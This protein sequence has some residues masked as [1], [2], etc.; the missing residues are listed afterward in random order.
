MLVAK[1][2]PTNRAITTYVYA[3]SDKKRVVTLKQLISKSE[4][5]ERLGPGDKVADDL[6]IAPIS[7]QTF[8]SLRSQYMNKGIRPGRPTQAYGVFSGGKLMGAYAIDVSGTK[9]VWEKHLSTPAIYLMSDFPVEP[10]DYDK[11]AKL[12]IVAAL[13]KESKLL[14]ERLTRRRVK[15]IITTAFSKNPVSMKYRGLF[16]LLKRKENKIL[17][18]TDWAKEV[19]NDYYRRPF[20]LEYG[21][22]AGQWTLAEGLEI[23]KKKYSQRFGAKETEQ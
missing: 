12:V 4:S 1:I 19:D 21:A 20:A 5:F 3:K 6:S 15:S 7:Q 11:L 9:M 8:F 16:K 13:S 17:E 2:K 18:E 22:E 14:M 23:W 10:V